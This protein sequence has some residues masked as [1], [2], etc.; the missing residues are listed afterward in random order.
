LAA[1][2]EAVGSVSAD[3]AAALG[4]PKSLLQKDELAKLECMA[5]ELGLSR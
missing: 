2:D 5:E 3:E 4:V 1:H